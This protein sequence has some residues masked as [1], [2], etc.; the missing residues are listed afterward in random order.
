[1]TSPMQQVQQQDGS[2]PLSLDAA[3][4]VAGMVA[5]VRGAGRPYT[6]PAE[7]RSLSPEFFADLYEV[8]PDGHRPYG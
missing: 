6:T 5:A 8:Q 1:M 2:Y 7:C 4:T 3:A